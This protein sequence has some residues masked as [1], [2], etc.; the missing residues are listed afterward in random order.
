MSE[1]LILS[2]DYDIRYSRLTDISYLKNWLIDPRIMQYFP[3]EYMQTHEI[4]TFSKNWI[5]F[6]RFRASLTATYRKHPV[7][8]ATIFLMPYKKVAH[9][10]LIYLIVDPIWQNKGIGSSLLK[11]IIHLA[12]TEFPLDSLH[13]E[14][15]E[16]NPSIHILK[17]FGFQEVIRQ[18]GYFKIHGQYH[19]R[20][21]MEIKLK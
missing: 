2:T 10:G 19:A 12:K 6:S 20:V 11:N 16:T 13:F 18:E 1:D 3:F 4:D 5:G 9:L 17:K 14:L 8:I 7:G 21:V 15:I